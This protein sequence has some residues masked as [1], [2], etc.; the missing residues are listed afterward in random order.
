MSYESFAH[1]LEF[2]VAEVYVKGIAAAEAFGELFG[3]KDGAMLAAG[4]AEGDHQ[5]FE[6]AGLIIGDACVNERVNGCKELVNVLL[7]VEIF[8]YGS[9]L[10]GKFFESFFTAGIRKASAVENEAAAIAAF[11]FG[12]FAVKGETADTHDEVVSLVGDT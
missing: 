5:A 2:D 7:L 10:A 4:A 1:F 9:V 3:E 8:D 12:Q 6:T 11:V